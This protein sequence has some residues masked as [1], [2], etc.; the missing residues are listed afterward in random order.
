M[1]YVYWDENFEYVMD[2]DPDH[3]DDFDAANIGSKYFPLHSFDDE[4]AIKY[5]NKK[6]IDGISDYWMHQGVQHREGGPCVIGRY[7]IE[8]RKLGIYNR[9]DG[10]AIINGNF[11][12]R[13]DWKNID[14]VNIRQS[15][16]SINN[17]GIDETDYKNWLDEMG[18]D[19]NNLTEEDKL[20]ID[21]KWS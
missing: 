17:V 10:P 15:V 12:F 7:R 8:W 13:P 14:P 20:L 6:E 2:A 19:I 4:P 11:G 18:M 1:K 21:L 3:I 16:W 5:Y 9:H